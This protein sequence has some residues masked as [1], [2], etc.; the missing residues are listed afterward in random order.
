MG[1]HGMTLDE[2]L[3]EVGNLG[4]FSMRAIYDA[5]ASN[6]EHASAS[7]SRA[8]RARRPSNQSG[9][10]LWLDGTAEDSDCSWTQDEE[11]G[12]FY[13]DIRRQLDTFA[14]ADEQTNMT[15]A[16][17]SKQQR[18]FVHATAQLMRLGH[19]SLGPQNKYRQM[20]VFKSAPATITRLDSIPS[21]KE[22]SQS[23]GGA[24]PPPLPVEGL[25]VPK[26]R[27]LERSANGFPCHY[28]DCGKTFDRASERTKHAQG[29]QA[30][31]TGRFPC[32]V[33]GKGFRYPKDVR[34][35]YKT[36]EKGAPSSMGLSC[37]FGSTGLGST[38]TSDSRVPSDTSLTFSS[39]TVSKDV[40][41]FLP[42]QSGGDLSQLNMEPL[43][44]EDQAWLD[45]TAVGA[46]DDWL[47][48]PY[49]TYSNIEDGDFLEMA[50]V[51][52]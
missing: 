37:S 44:L 51:R 25:H 35:H 38:L 50:Q 14:A 19:A 16:F 9:D 18:R 43:V 32:P 39:N 20:I 21:G 1:S 41:P 33:C 24:I 10:G 28:P 5:L 15:T 27:R 45:E 30:A 4:T 13:F 47:L 12:T 11:S 46:M 49:T 26:R 7:T 34:R 29:H 22:L 17:L 31:Y 23:L 2:Q 48:E 42:P 40:S 3:L 36:H 52:K 8:A 6:N